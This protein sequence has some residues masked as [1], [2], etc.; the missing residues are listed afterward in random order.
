MTKEKVSS[1]SNSKKLNGSSKILADAMKQ[2]FNEVAD[3]AASKAVEPVMKELKG[4]K[5]DVEGVKGD[6]EGV[7]GD[8]EG[9]KRGIKVTN[10]NMQSQFAEQEKKIG[11]LQSDV[12]DIHKAVSGS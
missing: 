2:V 6:I 12:N 7:K 9:V 11:K 3:Q 8:I 1:M 4:I 5:S 10:K